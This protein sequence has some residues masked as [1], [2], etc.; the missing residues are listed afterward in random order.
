MF[1]DSAN[2]V[3]LAFSFLEKRSTPNGFIACFDFQ[4]K[5]AI[6]EAAASFKQ[7][8]LAF[9]RITS[10]CILSDSLVLVMVRAVALI[11]LLISSVTVFEPL[12]S[13]SS[14]IGIVAGEAARIFPINSPLAK[15]DKRCGGTLKLRRFMRAALVLA[16][17]ANF[18]RY[19]FVI[20]IY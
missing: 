2:L 10:E 15:V 17:R 20:C 16:S 19:G 5:T 6:A 7:R 4:T 12:S 11:A 3:I 8:I 9:V 18:C 1:S 13:G 14:L